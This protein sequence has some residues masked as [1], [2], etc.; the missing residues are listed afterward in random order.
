MMAETLASVISS[1]PPPTSTAADM[2]NTTI[3]PTCGGPFPSRRTSRSAISTPS[4]TPPVSS[5]ARWRCWPIVAPRQ[6]TAAIGAKPVSRSDSRSFARYQATK[7]APAVS[8]IGHTCVRSRRKF[9]LERV[10]G[11]SVIED[12]DLADR[13]PAGMP[14]AAHQ[15]SPPAPSAAAAPIRLYR[16]RIGRASGRWA[17]RGALIVVFPHVTLSGMRESARRSHGLFPR[18]RRPERSRTGSGLRRPRTRPPEGVNVPSPRPARG[19]RRSFGHVSYVDAIC[20][21]LPGM[22]DRQPSSMM[23][24]ATA[25]GCGP[26]ASGTSPARRTPLGSGPAG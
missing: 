9:C 7:A 5:S 11:V 17:P 21:L 6:I 4:T 26:R 18:W 12:L 24:C 14:H 19:S 25:A 16:R 23:R 20:H 1:G 13:A 15:R 10:A 3:R 22:D 2:A 8:R